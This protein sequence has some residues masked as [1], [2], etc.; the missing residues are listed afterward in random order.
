[1]RPD[2]PYL[3][4]LTLRPNSALDALHALRPDG[5][6]VASLAL[7]SDLALDA[8]LPSRP[9]VSLRSWQLALAAFAHLA[10]FAS[11]TG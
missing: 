4:A 3:A 7:G 1:L 8:L 9:Q 5:S 6:Q 11:L 10:A 2:G